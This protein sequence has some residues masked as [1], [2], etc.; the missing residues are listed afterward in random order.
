[1]PDNVKIENRVNCFDDISFKNSAKPKGFLFI[2]VLNR[3]YEDRNL[4]VNCAIM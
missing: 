4:Q 1:M 3:L 2:N